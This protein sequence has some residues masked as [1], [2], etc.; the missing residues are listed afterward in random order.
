M[1]LGFN[2]R[3]CTRKVPVAGL[4]RQSSHNVAPKVSI[5]GVAPKASAQLVL[6]ELDHSQSPGMECLATEKGEYLRPRWPSV[7]SDAPSGMSTLVGGKRF[8]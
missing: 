2:N 5:Y 7:H 6:E 4:I 3:V 1:L 8:L